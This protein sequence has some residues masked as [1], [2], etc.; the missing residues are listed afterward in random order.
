ML[1]CETVAQVRQEGCNSYW[2][3]GKDLYVSNW[4]CFMNVAR[5]KREKNVVVYQFKDKIY[6]ITVKD[7]KRGC[8]FLVS[9]SKKYAKELFR[10]SR[11]NGDMF[12]LFSKI[13]ARQSGVEGEV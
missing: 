3:N 11:G 7:I 6:Y 12:R 4:M 8:N 2:I 9:Y 10:E 13:D 5:V 1:G